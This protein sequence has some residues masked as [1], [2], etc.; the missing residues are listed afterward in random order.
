MPECS[1]CVPLLR[2]LRRSAWAGR[3]SL[4]PAAPGTAG[5]PPAQFGRQSLLGR[6]IHILSRL[7][8]RH[9]LRRRRCRRCRWLRCLAVGWA[10]AA[11]GAAAVAAVLFKGYWGCCCWRGH[12]L[13]GA[14]ALTSAAVA[15]K[16][17]LCFWVTTRDHSSLSGHPQRRLVDSHCASAANVFGFA[18]YKH[19]TSAAGVQLRRR[20]DPQAQNKA[21]EKTQ[22]TK[23]CRKTAKPNIPEK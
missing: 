1:C 17:C 21:Q 11:G 3:T 23:R 10:A 20:T 9:Q 2:R 15:V 5:P 8:H 18:L 7:P 12:V 13:G 19:R 22:G 16:K 4:G 14:R 6:Q